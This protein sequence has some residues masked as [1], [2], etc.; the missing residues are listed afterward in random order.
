MRKVSQKEEQVTGKIDNAS[1]T[2]S[3]YIRL[4]DLPNEQII[5]LMNKLSEFIRPEHFGIMNNLNR[6]LRASLSGNFVLGGI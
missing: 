4:F 6:L 2:E 3:I 5:R 1:Q